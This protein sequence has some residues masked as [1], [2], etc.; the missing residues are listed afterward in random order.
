MI[1]TIEGRVL[2]MMAAVGSPRN[3]WGEAALA[4]AYLFMF[5]PSSTLPGGCSPLE[6]WSGVKPDVSH[7][8]VWGVR[9]F[10]RV[11]LELQTKLGPRSREC[12]FMGY[13]DGVKGYRVRDKSMGTFFNSRDVIF[14]ESSVNSPGSAPD[15]FFDNLPV[16][17]SSSSVPSTVPPSSVSPSCTSLESPPSVVPVAPSSVSSSC[18]SLSSLS[19]LSSS[20]GSSSAPAEVIPHPVQLAPLRPPLAAESQLVLVKLTPSL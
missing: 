16:V 14:D 2:S 9:C 7:L 3:L 11:P 6:F 18:S 19:S 8:R 17:S 20:S 15:D 5:T 12:T 4:S 1:Q 13:P 10:A